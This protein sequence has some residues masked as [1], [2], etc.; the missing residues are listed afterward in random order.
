MQSILLIDPSHII[1]KIGRKLFS[2]FGFIFFEASNLCE[3]KD[4]FEKESMPDYVVVDEAIEGV[5]EFI[6]DI[7]KIPSGGN[8]FIYY[9]L[10]EVD[11]TKMISGAKAGANSFL[12]KPFNKETLKFAM[13]NLPQMQQ[14]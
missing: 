9:L 5:L 12:L 13:R 11:F 2:D 4:F 14:V 7:R 8:T 1:R 10:V 6:S 3:A